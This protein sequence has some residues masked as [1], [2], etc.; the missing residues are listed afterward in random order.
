MSYVEVRDDA[1]WV[2]HIHGNNTLQSRILAMPQ[3]T[4][5]ELEVDGVRSLWKKMDN[6]VDGRPT[7]GIKPI[8]AGHSA[9]G[10]L[11]ARRGAVVSIR[12]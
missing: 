7:N 12:E 8:G 4:L 6:G 3:G 9:W 5:I 1:I 2:K 10:K 11:Q